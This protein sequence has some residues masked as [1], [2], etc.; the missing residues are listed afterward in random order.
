MTRIFALTA[1]AALLSAGAALAQTAATNASPTPPA[2]ATPIGDAAPSKTAAAPVAGAN[3]F[4]RAQTARRLK[5]H[6]YSN[7]HG[8]TK[9]VN[10]V[11]RGMA[12]KDGKTGRVAVDYQG[13]ITPQ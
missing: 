13:N 5:E 4:T 6:G 11:W 10:G 12:R 3:S 9:D 8:L 2:V 1:M 7:V